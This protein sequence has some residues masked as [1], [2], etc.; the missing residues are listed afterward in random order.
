MA[1]MGSAWR[2]WFFCVV[3]SHCAG[4]QDS[5]L[6]KGSLGDLMQ[7]MQASDAGHGRFQ[8]Q[9]PLIGKPS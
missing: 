7:V 4:A 6:P 3:V 5:D 8:L 2:L 9:L 1:K